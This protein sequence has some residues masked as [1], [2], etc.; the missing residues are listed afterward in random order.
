MLVP[1]IPI[2]TDN[3]RLCNR[4]GCGPRNE[5]EGLMQQAKILRRPVVQELTGLSCSTIYAK[6]DTNSPYYDASFPAPVKLGKRA[7]GWRETDISTWLE[8]RSTKAA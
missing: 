4:F 7:V 5:K 6:M 8:S 2:L 1:C 3:L